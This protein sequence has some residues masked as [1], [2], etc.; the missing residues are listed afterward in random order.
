MLGSVSGLRN[1]SIPVFFVWVSL[2]FLEVLLFPGIARTHT[3]RLPS[4]LV[5][6]FGQ[7]LGLC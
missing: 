1:A 6:R 2:L 7:A 4:D 3:F 5:P